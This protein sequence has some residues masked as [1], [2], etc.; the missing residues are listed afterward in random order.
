MKKYISTNF[1]SVSF[2]FAMAKYSILII[3]VLI[4]IVKGKWWL[5]HIELPPGTSVNWNQSDLRFYA[6]VDCRL[7]A[8]S[9]RKSVARSTYM[10]TYTRH[11]YIGLSMFLH[12]KMQKARGMTRAQQGDIIQPWLPVAG[13]ILSK[14]V[15]AYGSCEGTLEGRT[16]KQYYVFPSKYYFVHSK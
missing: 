16:I 12:V 9:I 3:C 14:T 13:Y 1:C 4:C 8:T 2:R 10:F 5:L 6:L 15:G 7:S 11:L